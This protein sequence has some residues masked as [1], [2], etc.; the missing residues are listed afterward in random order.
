MEASENESENQKL[1]GANRAILRT[2]SLRFVAI[3]RIAFGIR[4]NCTVLDVQ[5]APRDSFELCL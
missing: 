3:E 2:R 4:W 1:S 5:G